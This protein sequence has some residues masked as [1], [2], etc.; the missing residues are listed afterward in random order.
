MS[1][2]YPFGIP[3]TSSFAESASHA[4]KIVKPDYQA[5][6]AL[7]AMTGPPGT[8]GID[9]TD[10]PA[11]YTSAI[12][13]TSPYTPIPSN[14][15]VNRSS[16]IL[17]FPLP[18]MTPTP[19][20][21]PTIT[22]TVT[23][24]PSVTVTPSKTP[25]PTRT[26]SRTLTP[27]P[28]VTPQATP[29]PTPSATRQIIALTLGGNISGGF[30]NFWKVNSSVA[31]PTDVT[32]DAGTTELKGYNDTESG[33][34]ACIANEPVVVGDTFPGLTLLQG[35]TTQTADGPGDLG[36]IVSRITNAT[37]INTNDGNGSILRV[38]GASWTDA[39]NYQWTLTI[40]DQTC[41]SNYPC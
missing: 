38:T 20:P 34:A 3:S 5:P 30:P 4:L 28:S 33:L 29:E 23:R 40:T 6:H 18:S 26:P 9:A 15:N 32:F 31:V 22:P 13:P 41:T 16:Y 19:T 25:A 12:S 11:G 17:C 36:C 24:T 2:F 39:N 10:C 7:T 14:P 21:T 1:T 37:F 35:T 8:R 27:T